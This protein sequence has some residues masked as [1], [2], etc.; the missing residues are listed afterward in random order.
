MDAAVTQAPDPEVDAGIEPTHGSGLPGPS[1][2][3]FVA[4]RSGALLRSAYLLT[5]DAAL[6]E[7]LLQTAWSKV[8]SRWP[9]LVS[10]GDPEPYVRRVLYTTY[11][12]WWRRRWTGERPT[13]AVPDEP[14]SGDDHAVSDLRT[15]LLAAL[16]VLP[17]GQRAV[18]VL[19]YFEDRTETETAAT[20]GCSVGTVKSQASRALARLRT[21]PLLAD[22]DRPD[23]TSEA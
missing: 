12:T 7:D 14:M 23:T 16:A 1:F 9:R 13:A 11:A 15:E 4:A 3:A 10:G 2:D 22:P 18:L 6:A 5:G 20:L 19:R 8:W 17:R 21:S